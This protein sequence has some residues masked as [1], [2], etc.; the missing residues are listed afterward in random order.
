MKKTAQL[1]KK[2]KFE[3]KSVFNRLRVQVFLLNHWLL[4]FSL[5]K[6]SSS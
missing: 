3:Y 6:P 5:D 1:D 2:S 4:N